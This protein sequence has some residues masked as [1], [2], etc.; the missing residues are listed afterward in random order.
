M[1]YKD[2]M[3]DSLETMQ[4]IRTKTQEF[5]D[6]LTFLSD[7]PKLYFI[8]SLKVRDA[9]ERY[10]YGLIDY[11]YHL[12]NIEMSTKETYYYDYVSK[13]V[14]DP[15]GFYFSIIRKGNSFPNLENEY[16]K[17]LAKYEDPNPNI[18]IFDSRGLRQVLT[19]AY[20]AKIDLTYEDYQSIIK[21]FE[22]DHYITE[23][24]FKQYKEDV[25][26]EYVADTVIDLLRA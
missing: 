12:I 23:E 22:E 2:L 21:G 20:E 1:N 17:C 10:S 25:V 16:N 4:H 11:K 9:E 3:R 5:F 26:E 14:R 8:A 19:M 7:L 24:E 15:G 13:K 6:S 18:S